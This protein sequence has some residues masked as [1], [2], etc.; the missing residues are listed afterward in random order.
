VA[1]AEFLLVRAQD[2]RDVG[3]GG[4]GVAQ[5]FVDQDLS[6]CVREVVV[7][8]DDM[9][10]PHLRVVHRGGEVV[11]WGVG[12]LHNDEVLEV[13]VLERHGAANKVVDDGLPLARGL[14]AHCERLP[15]FR[16]ASRLFWV[17]LA[18]LPTGVDWLPS[19]GACLLPKSGQFLGGCEVPVGDVGIE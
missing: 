11:G 17:H 7:A 12:G 14:H 5:S 6:R 10:D 9:A 1:L 16:P 4:Q 15:G 13:L 2:L 19:G 18:V 3:E 8:P